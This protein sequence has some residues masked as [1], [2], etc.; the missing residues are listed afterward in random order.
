MGARAAASSRLRA[1]RLASMV[2][3][4][5][6]A[7]A[8]KMRSRKGVTSSSVGRSG[9]PKFSSTT[10]TLTAC[11]LSRARLLE[12][13]RLHGLHDRGD[14]AVVRVRMQAVA[15]VED[16]TGPPARAGKHLT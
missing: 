13:E 10:P 15:E 2:V 14:H 8:W 1:P 3:R 9:S 7:F 5:R 11:A 4:S 6:C 16:V 12:I